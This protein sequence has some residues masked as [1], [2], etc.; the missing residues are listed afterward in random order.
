MIL[1]HIL[2]FTMLGPVIGIL[3]AV[4]HFSCLKAVSAHSHSEKTQPLLL[5]SFDG[6]R[7]DYLTRAQLPNIEKIIRGGVH[8]TEGVKAVFDTST[9]PNHWSLVTGLYPESH[10]VISNHLRDIDIERQF[11]P[12]YIDA[13]YHNDPRYYD[14]GGEPIWVTNQIQ[15]GRSGSIMW[16]GSEN[17]VKWSWPTLQMP[18]DDSVNFTARVDVI[19]D[20]L[21]QEQPVN[22]GLVYFSEPDSIG[23]KAGPESSN[24]TEAIKYT[25]VV[26]G[27][28]LDRLEE[29]DLLNQTNI[30][31]T[32][33]HGMA[34]TSNK[35]LVFLN[36]FVNIEDYDI[37][38][39]DTVIA[40]IFPHHGISLF[41]H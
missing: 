8:A 11:I 15:G 14:N 25:D 1:L 38:N 16:W 34:T 31:I 4:S 7:W 21:S 39:D 32:S 17:P 29:K 23:H 20:W 2:S 28:L 37:L 10:G 35:T 18:Y 41:L 24:V 6:F 5:I 27:Y 22:L 30:I 3:V 13:S 33:D 9:L 12:K 26:V 36:D 19:I 40:Q